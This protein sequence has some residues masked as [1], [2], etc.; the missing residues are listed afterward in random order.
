MFFEPTITWVP[1]RFSGY[2]WLDRKIVLKQN[3][4]NIADEMTLIYYVMY[5]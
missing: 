1:S 2:I 4:L 3:G 5:G